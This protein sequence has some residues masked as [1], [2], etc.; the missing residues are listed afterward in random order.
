MSRPISRRA[1]P[2][3]TAPGRA[4]CL[5]LAAW[6]SL[7]GGCTRK[8]WREQADDLAY[9]VIKKKEVDERWTLPRLDVTADPRSRFYDPFDP[10]F[11]P[12]PPDDP[13]A[14]EYMHWVYGMNGYKK[15]HEF[16]DLPAIENPDWLQPFGMS[17][18]V[19]AANYSK[20]AILPQIEKLTLEEAIELSWIH[21]RDYQTQIENVYLVALAL[22]FQRFQFDLQFVG[23]SVGRPSAQITMED[24]PGTADSVNLGR[25]GVNGLGTAGSVPFGAGVSQLFPS[26][27]QFVAELAN[28][29]LWLFS[30]GGKSDSTASV[31]SYSLVQPLLAN[32]GR[33]FVMEGLTLAERNMLYAL[34][35]LARYR[36]GFFTSTVVGGGTAGLTSGVQNVAQPL[37]AITTPVSNGGYLGLLQQFQVIY[38]LEYNITQL[39]EQLN[40]TQSGANQR[41]EWLGEDLPMLPDNLAVPPDPADTEKGIV[42]PQKFRDGV[43]PEQ[44]LGRLRYDGATKRL[45]LRGTVTDQEEQQLLDLSADLPWR[46]AIARLADLAVEENETINQP[47]AQLQTQ[48]ASNCNSLRQNRV[49]LQNTIDQYKLF[50]GLPPDMPITI[51]DA[52]LKPFQFI[53]PRLLRL[54][55]RLKAFVPDPPAIDD[56]HPDIE[57]MRRVEELFTRF[58]REPGV[59]VIRELVAEMELLQKDIQRD[60][61]DVLEDDFR[62]VVDHNENGPPKP[63]SDGCLQVYRDPESDLRLKRSLL[64]AFELTTANLRK[65]KQEFQR[66]NLTPEEIDENLKKLSSVR[67]EFFK[68]TRSLSV[69]QVNLRVDLID[70]NRFDLE[71]DEAVGV[72]LENRM[73]LMNL[74]AQVMDARRNVEVAANQLQAVLNIAAAGDIRTNPLLSGNSNPVDFRGD[75]SSIRVG[76]QFT[77]PVQLVAQRNTYRAALIAYQRARRNYMRVEDDIKLNI[78]IAWRQLNLQQQNFETARQQVRAAAAQLDIQSELSTAPTVGAAGSGGGSVSGLNTLNALSAVLNAQNAMIQI[79]VNFE[80][81]RLNIYN[82]MGTME[83]DEFGF[84]VDDFYQ[85]RAEAARAGR[86]VDDLPPRQPAQLI[87]PSPAQELN[88][89]P[90]DATESASPP[91]PTEARRSPPRRDRY[92]ELVK[93]ETW[94]ERPAPRPSRSDRKD[95][96]DADESPRGGPRSGD[97]VEAEAGGQGKRPRR[98]DRRNR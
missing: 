67:E 40:R 65:V 52:I 62:R 81:N 93:G 46:Q 51:D 9:N 38:N 87:P 36:M 70:L 14:H 22:T 64:S 92:L 44:F 17:Q 31:F 43:L 1:N 50:L 75:A 80:T 8:Y 58:D 95:P 54:Q 73:D 32:A 27:A 18:D 15:W 47:I 2:I 19:V 63:E 68:M 29:T 24:V 25:T 74:R 37:G 20:S 13:A 10:D 72:G 23:L 53:D 86:N 45:F 90:V 79:W 7:C 97:H 88:D 82:L 33:R 83:I 16:G 76:V 96:A 59:P 35:D 69:V 28:N 61:I 56:A 91:P 98:P 21:N 39:K 66:D 49:T 85:R 77:S 26:G 42:R 71:R 6:L 78:R 48:L 34:R 30:G 57:A 60:G 55:D 89:E 12:L 11:S 41:F 94:P 5:G 3:R 4:L 84:W